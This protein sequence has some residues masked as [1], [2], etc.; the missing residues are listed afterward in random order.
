MNDSKSTDTHVSLPKKPNVRIRWIIDVI[1]SRLVE[2]GEG[3][4]DAKGGWKLLNNL[5]QY[6]PFSPRRHKVDEQQENFEEEN[7]KKL[8]PGC[9][10]G[11]LI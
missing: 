6:L 4:N 9:D 10:N 1:E 3:Q 5:I 7:D 8:S 11:K 2:G